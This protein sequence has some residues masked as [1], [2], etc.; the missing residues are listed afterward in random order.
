MI[1]N[2]LQKILKIHMGFRTTAYRVMLLAAIICFSGLW[3]ADL[4]CAVMLLTPEE[5]RLAAAPSRGTERESLTE[6]RFIIPESAVAGPDIQVLSPE[7][8]IAYPSPLKVLVK[9]FPREGTQ[10][11]LSSLKV[12][13]LKIFA[14]NITDR[15]RE[16]I[17][18]QGINVDKAE[19]PSGAHKIRVTLGDT[20]GGVTSRVFMVKVR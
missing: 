4:S 20:G 1:N 18:S 14:I 19:F 17:T 16:Y 10:V 13:C 2:F 11:D 15:I 3:Y 12:E 5:A 6:E 7:P 8:E 9:F